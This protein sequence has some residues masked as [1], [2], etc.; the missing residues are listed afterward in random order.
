[1]EDV[2]KLFKEAVYLGWSWACNECY[3][4][5]EKCPIAKLAKKYD[6]NYEYDVF[7]KFDKVLVLEKVLE[8]LK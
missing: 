6:P 8:E 7:C 5:P 2:R 3:W 1:M 4:E